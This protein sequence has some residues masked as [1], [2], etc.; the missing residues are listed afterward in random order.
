M[1][2]P[3]L[4][5]LLMT[6]ACMSAPALLFAAPAQEAMSMTPANT[7]TDPSVPSH[8]SRTP[9][10]IANMMAS[11]LSLTDDQKNQITPILADR[12]QQM[13]TLMADTTLSHRQKKQQMRQVRADG[14]SKINA[15][16][17]P[18]QQ[19]KYAQMHDKMKQRMQAKKDAAAS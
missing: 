15:I 11:K 8:T 1:K 7:A 19:T 4:A 16:L 6:A 13:Q 5:N 10:Q 2:S 17:T 9:D 18:E 12:Q 14:E 3:L